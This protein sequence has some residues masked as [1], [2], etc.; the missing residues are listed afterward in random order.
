MSRTATNNSN[1]IVLDTDHMIVDNVTVVTVE[2]IIQGE[3]VVVQGT[4][5]RHPDDR[6]DADTGIM[7]ATGRAYERLAENINRRANGQVKHNDDIAEH[8]DFIR[9]NEANH[10]RKRRYWQ[11]K[12][13]AAN[14]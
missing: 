7:V 12:M 8:R 3:V 1:V 11:R 4:A 5:I 10:K 2:A 9:A 14:A 13:A 6:F